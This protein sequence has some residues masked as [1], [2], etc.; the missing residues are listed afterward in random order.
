[1]LKPM[2]V[3]L[4]HLWRA[5]RRS[6]AS[7]A[8]AI[9]TLAVTIGVGAS[10]FA[11]VD[12]VLLT[13][14]PFIDPDSL[15]TVSET[16]LDDTSAVPRAINS[17]T[18]DAWRDRAR[19]LATFEGFDPTNLTLTGIGAAER[20]RATDVTPGFLGLLG[21]AP[22]MGRQF[23][24]GDVGQ[25]VAIV[26]DGFWRRT[27]AADPTAVGR[28]IVL[29]GQT[30]TI[31]GVLPQHFFFA[32]DVADIYRPLPSTSAQTTREGVR[33]RVVA[34]L[35]PDVSAASLTTALNDVSRQSTPAAAVVTTRL[36]TAIAGGSQLTLGLL[37]GAA[38]LALLIAFINL[39]GLLVVRSL[40]RARELAV[41]S[42]LGAR[43]G[44]IARQL[45]LESFAL[46]AI[47]TIAGVLLAF[48]LTPEAG[49]LALQQFGGIAT[50]DVA[51]G[52]RVIGV[53][54]VIAVTCAAACGL[55]PAVVASRRTVA[56]ILR[57][58]ATAG[59]RERWLRRG[60]VTAVVSL[61]FVLLVSVSLVGRS[62]MTVLAID[63]GFEPNG[64]MTAGVALPP[65]RYQ[66]DDQLVSFYSMLEGDLSQRLGQRGVAF[67]N[68]LP[69]NND[70]GRGLVSTRP[71]DHGREAVIRV[72]STA[73]FDVMRIGIVDGRTFERR[74]DAT[75]PSRVV[76]SEWLALRLFPRQSAVGRQVFLDAGATPAEVIGVVRDV[77]HRS[78][79]ES[80][81]PTV[82][83]SAWQ[84]PSRGNVIVMR[85]RFTDS[86]ALAVLR[87]QVARIDRDL[88]VYGQ[89][90]LT[91]L[92][93]RSPGVPA[94][95]VL[96]TAFLGFALLAVVLGAIGLFGV[97]AHD[98]ASRRSELALRLALGADPRRLLAATLRQGASLVSGSLALGALLS[99]W[100]SPA[101][102]GL[103]TIS[104][105]VDLQ[106]LGAASVVLLAVGLCSVLPAARRAAS[107]DPL[108]ILRGE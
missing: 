42:A 80:T 1:M 37:A 78:L 21:V 36:A 23:T 104:G 47:G 11:V 59:P 91:D 2:R 66:T 40:D 54:S 89:A 48:W 88:P 22:A 71:T 81:L 64:V 90:S 69:L 9:L 3:D 35:A 20:L 98:V 28:A 19:R 76:I 55:L 107:T 46:V 7:A 44:D 31:V 77:K 26:S 100:T 16:P 108:A 92:V 49:R 70:R 43:R 93:A 102:G 24:S 96:T 94:R 58:G 103:V 50:R 18:F 5:L 8:A 99:L 63:P 13:K 17:R 56:D 60:F 57:R 34:R 105:G 4:L 73:Y 12:S 106:S 25:P 10:I 95:R 41:R 39:A 45:M 51:V 62:L 65:V 79:D 67:V 87:E 29:G 86:D 72:A 97:I 68:E 84:S 101:L 85:T 53:V 30:H 75:A 27:L 15:V 33:L 52:W 6:P 82:Y 74:D 14:P 83:R 38:V 32:L 61:A